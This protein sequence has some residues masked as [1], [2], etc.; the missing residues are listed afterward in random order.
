MF[1]TKVV[2]ASGVKKVISRAKVAKYSTLLLILGL[3]FLL[4]NAVFA[5]DELKPEITQALAAGDTT[6]AI[7]L[8]EHEIAIDKGY[9]ANY[10]TLGRIYYNREQYEKAVEQLQ[11][12][13]D[14]KGRHFQSLY[15]LGLSHLKLNHL[16]EAAKIM[17]DGRKKARNSEKGWFENG[18]GLV[19]LARKNYAEAD[20]AFRSALVA[21]GKN[22][23]YHI[24]LGDAN[25]YQGIP[26][27]AVIEYQKALEVDTGSTEVYF[28]WAEA[29]LDMKDYLCAIEKLKIVVDK[30]ST[31]APAWMRA[32]G[33]YF[34]AALSTS[35]R[36]DRK[37]RFMDAIG[38]YKRYLDLSSVQPD[39][40]HVRVFFELAMSYVNIGG[41]EEAAKYF[42]AV[43]SIPYEARDIY[44]YYAKALWGIQDYVKCGEM[45]QKHLDWLQREGENANSKVSEDELDQLLGDS[46]FYREN[47]DYA[48]A[49][50]YYQKSIDINP[51]QK[52]VMY[53]L[54]VAYHSLK[55]LGRALDCYQRRIA[56]GI[57]SGKA[58]IYKNAGYCAL[59]IANKGESVDEEVN[60]DEGAGGQEPAVRDQQYIDTTVNYYKIAADYMAKYLEATPDD[61]KALLLTANTYLYQLADCANA[62]KYYQQLLG[63]DPNNFDAKKAVGYAYFGGVCT[64][65]FSKALTYLLDAYRIL[66]SKGNKCADVD[67]M[68]WIGQCY[69]LRAVDKALA[70]Q[71]DFKNANEWYT[72]CLSCDP[73][74][75]ACK[76]GRDDTSFEF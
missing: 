40:G 54:A 9:H 66:S 57:D 25:F 47:K 7:K 62:V 6:Q 67:L 27:L 12:A 55:Q 34:R 33:I 51:D 28:H 43:L 14:R 36:D 5:A 30:D 76:K 29:C 44:F 11:A 20:R 35:D 58:S 75:A 70:Q 26:S 42:E 17:D 46:Y 41:S 3:F 10:Y 72:K 68:L 18:Y 50:R 74:N 61:A 19:M 49:A 4:S 52:R 24:N 15:Y 32:G 22:P 16:D 38:A 45:L 59:S 31:Y 39:S 21:D 23:E 64:K 2:L 37:E 48:A 73:G 65:D 63:I 1:Y 56:M 13:V 60:L 69:H 53:N 8:L 71:G